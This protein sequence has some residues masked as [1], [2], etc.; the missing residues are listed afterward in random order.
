MEE[1][2]GG[3]ALPSLGLPGLPGRDSA[4]G[5]ALFVS[6]TRWRLGQ[7]LKVTVVPGLG[8]AEG[9]GVFFPHCGKELILFCGKF[10]DLLS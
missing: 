5:V 1:V 9:G 10:N 4:L 2:L 3:K 6:V 7:A 8:G